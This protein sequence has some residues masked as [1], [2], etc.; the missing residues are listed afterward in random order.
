MEIV[1]KYPCEG[2]Y[3]FSAA[4]HQH[5]QLAAAAEMQLF[6]HKAQRHFTKV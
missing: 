5:S 6:L 2:Q 1:K 4:P 3:I